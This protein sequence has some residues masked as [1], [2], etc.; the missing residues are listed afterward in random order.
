MALTSITKDF[1]TRAGIVVQGTN[2]VFSSTNQSGALQVNG[3]TAIAKNLIVGTTATF[4]GNANVVGDLTVYGAT[5]LGN[6]GVENFTATNLS[7]T[8]DAR[9]GNGF[10]VTGATSL[11]STLSATGDATFSSNALV[12]G[13][14]TATGAAQLGSTLN[15][16]GNVTAQANASVAGLF[17]ATGAAQ[18]GSTLNVVG[19]VTAQANASVGGLFTA[20]GATTLKDTLTVTN[21]TVLNS[22]LNVTGTIYAQTLAGVNGGIVFVNNGVLTDSSNLTWDGTTVTVTGNE[23]VSGLFTA[24]GAATFGSTVDVTGDLTVLSNTHATTAGVGAIAVTGGVYVG[25]NLIV[26]ST[27]ADTST[28]YNN[29]LYVAGGAWIDK[30]LNVRGPVVFGDTVTFNGTATY[31][32]STNTWYTDNIIELHTPPGGVDTTWTTDDGK[33]IGLRFHYYQGAD[34]N[35]AL[36]LANDTHYL[37]WYNAGAELVG[38]TFSGASYGTFKTGSIKLADTTASSSTSTGSLTL[39]GGA[40]I[41]GDVYVGGKINVAKLTWTSDID[42]TVTTASNI[43]LGGLGEIPIQS[44]AGNTAFIAAGTANNQVLTWNSTNSTASWVSAG[45]TT[46]G[47]ATTATNIDGG[48]QFDIPFQSAPGIT[49]FDTGV[50]TYNNTTNVLTVNNV[51]VNG[52]SG[53]DA[54]TQVAAASGQSIELYSNDFAELNYNGTNFVT[55]N[56]TGAAMSTAG[57]SA[58]LDTSGGFTVSGL[59]ANA[60]AVVYVDG[61]GKLIVN[62]ANLSW[63]STTT[64]LAVNGTVKGNYVNP[65]NLTSG[66]VTFYNGTQLSDAATLTWDGTVFSAANV[67]PAN[68]TSGRVPFYNGSQLTDTANLT[69]D[70]TVFSASNVNPANLTSGRVTFYNGTQ[71]TDS[72]NLT[73][74]GTKLAVTGNASVTGNA[75]VNGKVTA[76]TVWATGTNATFSTSTGGAVEVKGGVGIAKD[77]YVG[78][79]ATIGGDLYVD[80][81]IF[82]KGVGLNTISASTGTFDFVVIEGT[83]TGLTVYDGAVVQGTTQAYNISSGAFQVAGGAGIT[84]NLHVGGDLWVTG[85]SHLSNIAI[86]GATLESLTVT[87]NTNVAGFTATSADVTSLQI[88]STN[89]AGYIYGYDLNVANEGLGVRGAVKTLKNLYVG[90]VGY[91]GLNDAG[92][93][94]GQS[95][96]GKAIDGVF[97]VNS[98]QSGGTYNHNAATAKTID[99]WDKTTYTSAKYMVQIVQGSDIHTQEIMVIQDGSN[100]YMSEYGIVANNGQLGVFD[101]SISGSN[102]VITFTPTSASACTINVVRQSILTGVENYC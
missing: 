65:T 90:K 54:T 75:D 23:S 91:F 45:G 64:T 50:F 17:T 72:A 98:M 2:A 80:G 3:G 63:I 68:L 18:L 60:G 69:W 21:G 41:A 35:A 37:E 7:V 61:N 48:A 12:S 26:Y 15:V 56:S 47:R 49:T 73:W 33:D 102:V 67:N 22:T 16:V 43:K 99:T 59:S 40:G 27:A 28:N 96:V 8:N 57:G 86:G 93:V 97:I 11:L 77:L 39:E 29:A 38:G 83:G 88:E 4:W 5:N 30:D 1:I 10:T 24:T 100:V 19:N 62:A 71:L 25:D 82:M 6:I 92:D 13:L 78:T 74:D 14:F 32:Y 31:V 42:A 76:Q 95:P 46:V 66:R 9:V 34:K 52:A 79:T 84:K 85:T 36:V 87:G 101:G 81:E 51:T 94:T 55:V 44:A 20:T 53:N 70:G 58:T 89:D